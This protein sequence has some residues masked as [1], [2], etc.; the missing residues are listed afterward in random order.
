MTVRSKTA[1]A[2]AVVAVGTVMTT[3][4]ATAEI[5]SVPGEPRTVT[6]DVVN[7]SMT[8][9]ALRSFGTGVEVLSSLVEIH[10]DATISLPFEATLA[11]LAAAR[12]P[13]VAPNVLSYLVQRFV[14]PSVGAPIYAYPWETE[15]TVALFATLLPHPLGPSATDPGLV[16]RAGNAF[17]DVFDSVLGLLPD[18]LPGYEAVRDVMSDNSIGSAIVAAQQLVRAPLYTAVAVVNQ[19][20]NLPLRVAEAV[21]STAP[22]PGLAPSADRAPEPVGVSGLVTTPEDPAAD[23]AERVGGLGLGPLR[24]DGLTGASGRDASRPHRT[25]PLFGSGRAGAAGE[26]AVR[27]PRPAGTTTAATTA[28]RPEATSGSSGLGAGPDS[29]QPGSG[30]AGN[31]A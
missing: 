19:L 10:V 21:E 15:Q 3:P 9:N 2:T 11:V 22:A 20:G 26:H 14:N 24:S 30:Q 6:V 27:L 18:P 17:A 4:V 28:T 23:V 12:H 5:A 25:R 29:G 13:E 7:A 8:T 31:E 16:I 1:F